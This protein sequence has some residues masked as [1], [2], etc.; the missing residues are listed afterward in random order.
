M[1][2]GARYF[3]R[4]MRGWAELIRTPVAPDPHGLVRRNLEDRTANFLDLVRRVV[5]A[6]ASNPYQVMFPWAGCPYSDL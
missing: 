2:R 4:M 6:N 5:F 3:A 1:L